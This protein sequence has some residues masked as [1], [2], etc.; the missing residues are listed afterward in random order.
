[1]DKIYVANSLIEGAGRG[2]FA[3][4]DIQK[5]DLIEHCPVIRLLQSSDYDLI[6]HTSLDHYYF[7]WQ[8]QDGTKGCAL[9]L[10]YGSLYNHSP[11]PNAGYTKLYDN[12]VI[13]F[14]A[15]EPIARGQEITVDYKFDSSEDKAA[16][17]ETQS[18]LAAGQSL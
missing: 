7:T 4:V 2:V 9:S 16:W 18:Q 15:L 8:S 1:M 10:G 12:D 13:E 5:G 17:I 14:R 11:K 6:K 3:A